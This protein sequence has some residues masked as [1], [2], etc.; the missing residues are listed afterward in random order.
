MRNG[1]STDASALYEYT[2]GVYGMLKIKLSLNILKLCALMENIGYKLARHIGKS[3]KYL[4]LR[5]SLG[6]NESAKTVLLVA[7]AV[8]S[9]TVYGVTYFKY[10]E[11]VVKSAVFLSK[12]K[13]SGDHRDTKALMIGSLCVD[14]LNVIDSLD[15]KLLILSRIR[16][17]VGMNLVHTVALN[18]DI[19]HSVLL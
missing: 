19:L 12:G 16:P 3:H 15:T 4:F 13:E 7:G 5:A 18:E 6:V 9:Q 1:K 11:L 14:D 8:S 17:D 2:V 10:S